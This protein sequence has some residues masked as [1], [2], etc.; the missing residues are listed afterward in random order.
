MNKT[1]L[2]ICANTL[3]IGGIE[4]SLINLLLNLPD[5]YKITLM[6]QEK[7]GEL[8][9]KLPE[10]IEIIEYKI[11]DNTNVFLRKLKNR[12]K[13][14]STIIKNK[15]KFDIAICYA[16]YDYPSS[17]LSRHLGK[18]SVLW[19]HS[20]YYN[21]YKKDSIKMLS[22]F[23]KRKIKKF[24]KLVFVSNE[25][26]QDLIKHYQDLEKKSV[27]I[28]NLIDYKNIIE[29]SK[30]KIITKE[31]PTI[32]FLGRLEEESKGLMLLFSLANKLKEFDLWIVGDGPDKEKYLNYI[33]THKIKNVKFY[34]MK[35]N[36][37][38]YIKCCDL[39][40][41]PSIYEGFPVVILEALTLGKKVLTTINVS[42]NKFNLKNHVFLTTRD[43]QQLYI[44]IKKT[45]EIKSTTNFDYKKFNH[46]NIELVKKIL[47]DL[48][49]I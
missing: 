5:K 43:K 33:K 27:V 15:N 10:N 25:S 49:E 37:Y 17:I 23:N 2:L 38:P 19:I 32:L 44:D 26:K 18:K 42:S 30:E 21:I 13:L 24:N 8:L 3:E 22:F 40:I 48:Y 45:F 11:S 12:T 39:L 47:E 6:L 1:K 9:N 35:S 31:N 46:D 36:P 34:G 28:N 4:T 41:L 29:K 20:N 7:K 16:T 14:F